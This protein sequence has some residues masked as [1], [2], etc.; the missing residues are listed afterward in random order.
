MGDGRA[1]TPTSVVSS[2]SVVGEDGCKSGEATVQHF[3]CGGE[4]FP[5]VP[6]KVSN[7]KFVGVDLD[8]PVLRPATRSI[9][10]TG[11]VSCV[12]E[13]S[14]SE[15]ARQDGVLLRP[16][17]MQLIYLAARIVLGMATVALLFACIR[18]LLRKF[19]SGG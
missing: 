1:A 9:G 8:G 3:L 6:Y 19:G 13:S 15:Q 2:V 11:A 16:S 17:R 14:L 10:D 4:L 7:G 18:S 5:F 12:G